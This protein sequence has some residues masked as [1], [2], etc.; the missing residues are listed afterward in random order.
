MDLTLIIL[1]F[2][3]GIVGATVGGLNAFIWTG[4]VG[5]AAMGVDAATGIGMV[6]SVAFGF[7]FA[8]L[9]AFFGGAI[10]VAYAR[11]MGY[12]ESGK[13]IGMA[14]AGI[15]KPDVLLVGGV[16]AVIG[17]V[18][19][20]LM[21]SPDYIGW[22]GVDGM[23]FWIFILSVVGKAIF[24]GGK[25]FGTVSDEA[26]AAGGRFGGHTVACWLPWQRTG[27]EK[28]V[29]G[30]GWSLVAGFA[31]FTL[32]QNPATA[33]FAPFLGFFIS[34]SSLILLLY[35]TLIPVTHH[36][37][38]PAGYAVMAYIGAGGTDPAMALIWAAGIGIASAF[39]AD[40]WSDVF[41]A[42]GDVHVDPPAMAIATTS[43]FLMTIMPMFGTAM[44]TGVV[45]PL[46]LVAICLVVAVL[47]KS[48]KTETA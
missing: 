15:K 34:A 39:I 25:I 46:V 43:L 26:K 13:D 1:V 14:L 45:V 31:T 7:W 12:V 36:I 3:T 8:P 29:I 32:A 27:W 2:A 22:A 17:Y 11:K 6:G 38:L 28:L 9:Y 30:L 24:D 41:H 44:M 48:P 20:I 5:L 23:A 37:T 19:L 40:F 10:A 33:G 18:C 42:Y 35:G 21:T 4:F 47:G 16:A